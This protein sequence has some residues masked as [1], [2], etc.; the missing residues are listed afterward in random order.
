MSLH[1]TCL[2][3]LPNE[4]LFLILKK[5]S[6]TDVLYS[7]LSINN[8]RLNNLAQDKTFTNILNFTHMSSDD[9]ICSISDPI[10]DRFCV[11]ILPRICFQCQMSHSGIRF[12]GTYSSS[13][14]LS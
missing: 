6:N 2:L 7:L 12:Y 1:N 3:D 13:C 11:H 5:L 9:E 14:Q 8:Q 4:I 10:L